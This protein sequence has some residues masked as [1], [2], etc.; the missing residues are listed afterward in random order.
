MKVQLGLSNN[1]AK[2][3]SMFGKKLYSNKYSFIA[4]I[5]Q[6]AVDSHRMSGQKAPVVVGMSHKTFYIR[7]F[8]LSFTSKEDFI[9]KV[10][11]ILESGKSEE[12]TSDEDCPMGMHGIGTI[13]VSAYNSIWKYTVYMED[14][15]E[16]DCILEEV[17]GKGLTY[18]ISDYRTPSTK[19][20]KGTLFSVDIVPGTL[21]Y[22]IDNMKD[23][24]AYFKD[25][26]FEFSSEIVNMFRTLLT[27][28]TEFKLYQSDDFQI[29]T[30]NKNIE[31]HISLDQYAYRIRWDVLKIQPI[32]IPIALKFTMGDGLE[33]DLTRENLIYDEN[34][35]T[36]VLN[37]IR[38]VCTQLVERH[39]EVEKQEYEDIEKFYSAITGR[40]YLTIADMKFDITVA[41]LHS[42][43][44]FVQQKLKGV[45]DA[46]LA[47]TYC[48]NSNFG[49]N[50]YKLNWEITKWG[51]KVKSPLGYRKFVHTHMFLE[52]VEVT[53]KISGYM[54]ATYP[55]SG[56]YSLRS[57]SVFKGT[58]SYRTILGLPNL[59][60]YKE[61]YKKTGVNKIALIRKDVETLIQ[62]TENTYFK[63]LSSIKIPIIKKVRKVRE[64]QDDEHCI[65]FGRVS[66]SGPSPVY[67]SVWIKESD[68][69][70][71][72]NIIF[73][74]KDDKV[75][76]DLLYTIVQNTQSWH[77]VQS[78][79]NIASVTDKTYITLE[80]LKLKN[81][82]TLEEF[83]KG[84][85]KPFKELVTA[86]KIA[87]VY[88]KYTALFGYAPLIKT[89]I[90]DKMG[91]SME[92]IFKYT[93]SINL[94]EC[95]HLLK[96]SNSF[97]KSITTLGETLS[98]FDES[99]KNEYEYVVENI[100]KFDFV[101]LLPVAYFTNFSVVLKKLI[102]D[103][104]LQR[105]IE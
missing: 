73:S 83:L 66:K 60:S 4:E 88:R 62:H 23:K 5:C 44:K 57:I 9:K 46:N 82:M 3:H 7:D 32:Q 15:R 105:G 24:L 54:R 72:D 56:F 16:F 81:C 17:E 10:C 85:S 26:K 97:L 67:E 6:N 80:K 13:S 19:H 40:K 50:L 52:D 42:S 77:K 43:V 93:K 76:L 45:S 58:E 79:I 41:S 53:S 39:N 70:A 63:K 36:I 51:T 95:I 78:K 30:L 34:Y 31:M 99:V 28:N 84:E 14:G 2:L 98:L 22:L 92:H 90:S 29:S 89:H 74:K 47:V 59:K 8:G 68:I 75:K 87:D 64:K 104:K 96:A 101:T 100:E 49:K 103:I 20:K 37:K 35:K 38:K 55:D 33:A 69:L 86:I 71:K 12:K 1:T 27:L 48:K 25:I 21:T 91:T 11:T 102:E 94:E 18:Q 61:D 65:S